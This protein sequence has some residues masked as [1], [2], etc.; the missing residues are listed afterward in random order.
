MIIKIYKTQGC[1]SCAR[2][3]AVTKAVI[4]DLKSE[5]PK[6]SV[7]ELD[8]LNHPDDVVKY[9]IMSSPT[10]VIGNEVVSR[11]IP[12]EEILKEALRKHK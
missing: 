1:S 7:K 11:G 2:A 10:I 3:L 5:L 6:L 4:N 8:I 9:N 12:T